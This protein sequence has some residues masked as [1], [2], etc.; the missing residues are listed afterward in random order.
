MQG[1]QKGQFLKP[2]KPPRS[3]PPS[4]P[5]HRPPS[6][7]ESFLSANKMYKKHRTTYSNSLPSPAAGWCNLITGFLFLMRDPLLIK[8]VWVGFF[9]SISWRIVFQLVNSSIL[10]NNVLTCE[11]LY[12]VEL[13]YKTSIWTRTRDLYRKSPEPISAGGDGYGRVVQWMQRRPIGLN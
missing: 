10:P 13:H 11:S 5:D 6:T 9:F 7:V 3:K 2:N 12:S 8:N 4:A 1:H